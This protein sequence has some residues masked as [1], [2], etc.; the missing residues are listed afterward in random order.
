MY[1]GGPII[2]ILT[3]STCFLHTG[4]R[5][6]TNYW[7]SRW[8]EHAND[9]GS[10]TMYYLLTYIGLSYLSQAIDFL[11]IMTFTRGIWAASSRL[12][13]EMISSVLAAPLSWFTEQAISETLNRLSGDMATLDQSIFNSLVP[14]ISDIIQ[15][16]L[17]M[18]TIAT[19][20]PVFIV[21]AVIL[22]II[23]GLV[24]RM[25]EGASGLLSDLVSSSRS[26]VLSD[27]SEGLAGS[28]IIRA[29][30]STP[31]TFH[32]K[33]NHLLCVS[34]R[35]QLAQSNANQWLKF[36][37]GILA[38]A[39]NVLAAWLALSQTGIM[40][41]GFVGFCLSQATQLSDKVLALIYSFNRLSLDMQTVRYFWYRAEFLC[42]P[43]KHG[44]DSSNASGTIPS[45]CRRKSAQA[46]TAQRYL[47]AG[48]AL[49]L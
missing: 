30:S 47:R 12:H 24:S 23:S 26:P 2:A 46:K 42:A 28:M 1:F 8:V 38:T 19:K 13:T 34:S 31:A 5:I 45:W 15:C 7:M 16:C 43:T 11:R 10:N 41:A 3:V 27:F 6:G 20:L 17:M 25:Y 49:A 37:M 48:L 14:A 4:A 33:M 18:G 36:R 39:I 35:A 29:T 40:S 21:P 32:T 44:L 9:G 22:L